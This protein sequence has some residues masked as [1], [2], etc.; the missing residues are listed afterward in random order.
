MS[1]SGFFGYS[2]NKL[3]ITEPEQPCDHIERKDVKEI[4]D[5]EIPDIVGFAKCYRASTAG[6]SSDSSSPPQ[7]GRTE[8]PPNPLE[9]Y[10]MKLRNEIARFRTPS[11]PHIKRFVH[12]RHPPKIPSL[13]KDTQTDSHEEELIECQ[14][15]PSPLVGYV[16]EQTPQPMHTS[17]EREGIQ[18]VRRLPVPAVVPRHAYAGPLRN[19][20]QRTCRTARRARACLRRRCDVCC[21]L[22]CLMSTLSC[23]VSFRRVG[24]LWPRRRDSES[25]FFKILNWAWLKPCLEFIVTSQYHRSHCDS[26]PVRITKDFCMDIPELHILHMII[27]YNSKHQTCANLLDIELQTVVDCSARSWLRKKRCR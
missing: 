8:E 25:G 17:G 6:S 10:N 16:P 3:W 23:L 2:A 14:T 7:R 5:G 15:P 18:L 12:L 21:I 22:R 11:P 19:R 26:M 1:C 9:I 13:N 27:M 20:W 24:H 4:T